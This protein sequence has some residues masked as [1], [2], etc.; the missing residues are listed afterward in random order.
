M[1]PF[2]DTMGFVDCDT[3]KLILRVDDF[4]DPAKVVALAEL[5]SDIKQSSQRMAALK[6]LEYSFLVCNIGGAI[7]CFY[8]DVG[9]AQ[10]IDLVVLTMI[11]K[12]VTVGLS[13]HTIKARSGEMTMVTARGHI[14]DPERLGTNILPKSTTAG[15]W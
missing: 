1:A 14:A 12:D 8:T 9:V 13:L 5:G 7:Y 2:A 10:C 11:S 6:I 3:C 15:S 4:E